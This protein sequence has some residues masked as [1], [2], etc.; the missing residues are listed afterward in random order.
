M[1]NG[2]IKAYA[3]IVLIRL[4]YSG[5]HVMSKVAL[6]QGMSPFV[7]VFY[8]HG[9]AALVLIPAVLILE[10]PKAKQVTLK[11]A[12]KMFVHA[13]YG[14]ESMKLKKL[15]G[16]VKAAG[17]L[18]CVTG[19]T[20]LAFYQGPMLGS[21]NHHH[22]FQQA[23]SS[24]DPEGNAHSKT[25]W[26]LGI[27]LITLSN[28]LAGLWTV[29]L[30]PLIEETSKLMNTALQISWAAV[31]AFVVAVAVERDFNKWK[32]GW[33]VELATGV[34]VTALSYYMQM[35]T[36]TKGGRIFAGTLLIGGLYNVL[37]GKNIE[38]QDEVN[39]IVADKPEFEMQGK[40]AQMPG[41]AGTKV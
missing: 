3:A 7:F 17:I 33:D 10:R 23:N 30:G 12:A 39:D 21:F 34:V 16:N 25:Q 8:R 29:L 32:L 28:V 18:F 14:I 36:I 20:V 22:L 27:F 38:E 40:E 37:W 26:V 1:G 6:D 5:M 19:V 4:M 9:S 2:G 41:D 31:Q 13:L 15:H 35:W 24:D 11:I